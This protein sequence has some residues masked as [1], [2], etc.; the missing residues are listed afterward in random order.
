MLF[1]LN[2]VTAQQQESMRIS[3]DKDFND[4]IRRSPETWHTYGAIVGAVLL[5]SRKPMELKELV[6][7]CRRFARAN[8]RN[9]CKPVDRRTT[10]VSWTY[11]A[12]S[13]LE[14]AEAGI[15]TIYDD[16]NS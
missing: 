14:L 11:V 8:P 5:K 10:S 6:A 12:G 16:S 7:A 13:V 15:V 1:A 9:A 3:L 4:A 2:I